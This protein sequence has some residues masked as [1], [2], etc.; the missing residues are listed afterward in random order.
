M[1]LTSRLKEKYSQAQRRFKN[2]HPH[3]H[4]F[5]A[6]KGTPPEKLRHHAAE[7]V[8]T[9]A[10]AGALMLASPAIKTKDAK[11]AQLAPAEREQ[12]ISNELQAVL[13]PTVGALTPNQEASV[14]D[15]LEKYYKIHAAAQLDGNRLN[16]S[17]GYIGAEQ[18]LPR[19]PGD[20]VD[21]HD[22]YVASGITP[23]R[24]AW[25]Y[26]ASSK[27]GF[28][29]NLMN[30]EKYYVAVQT[31]YLPDWNTR[32]KELR[33]WYQYR[34]VILVNPVNGKTIIADIADS[35]PANWTGKQ[36]GGSPE[37]MA[38]LG[39]NV[40]PQKGAV[41]LFFVN[42]PDNRVSLGPLEYNMETK[43]AKRGAQII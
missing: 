8:T 12:L 19:Y 3:A 14:S 33:D 16:D 24:G 18:H 10:L 17:Y 30:K 11:L 1:T 41:L 36:F 5:L 38:Y 6:H 35:G 43:G 42:D 27:D 40:G 22:A 9:G 25:G 7:L 26:F 4:V 15:I 32:T 31:L 23:G 21:Q 34:K 2:R 37:V 39:L 13:P 29:Q 28:T 20:S